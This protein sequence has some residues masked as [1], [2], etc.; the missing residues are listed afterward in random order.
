MRSISAGTSKEEPMDQIAQL[1]EAQPTW[2][3][4]RIAKALGLS[5]HTVRKHREQ[6]EAR[7]EGTVP[8]YDRVVIV[9]DTQWPFQNPE[10]EAAVLEYI[11]NNPGKKLIHL[12]DGADFYSLAS[13]RKGLPPSERMYLRQEVD[14]VRSKFKEYAAAAESYGE[15]VFLKGNHD[16]RLDRYLEL[17]GGELF[18]LVGD[19]LSFESV[20]GAADAGWKVIGPY[21]RGCWVG[22]PGGL[23]ATHGD[24]ARSESGASAKA[25]LRKYGHSVIH[26]HTHRLGQVFQTMQSA[27]GDRTIVGVEAGTLADPYLTPRASH[28][29]DWQF[30]FAVVWVAKD[31]PRF[32]V[33]LVAITDGG[34]VS[35]GVKYGR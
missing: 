21:G 27:E 34:F 5:Y 15:L 32:H 1:R 12:G 25:H 10:A 13:F 26:G 30:G 6:L 20:T 8:G 31:S 14:V 7:A 22:Q 33:D 2:G 24:Y 35:G 9:P 18:D 19:V 3:D 11:R 23:W 16:E 29:S 17:H 28:F 4:R